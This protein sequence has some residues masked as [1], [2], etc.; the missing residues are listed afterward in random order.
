MIAALNISMNSL[1]DG[2][3]MTLS[4]VFGSLRLD[5]LDPD[6]VGTYRDY[7]ALHEQ[8]KSHAGSKSKSAL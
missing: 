7:V 2:K 3:I 4:M 6:L 8:H 1:L 5:L